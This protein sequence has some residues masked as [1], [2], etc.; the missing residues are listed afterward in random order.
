MN[1]NW[2]LGHFFLQA[3]ERFFLSL[4]WPQC[5][6]FLLDRRSRRGIVFLDR[7]SMNF[8]WW[9]IIPKISKFCN[10]LRSLYLFDSCILVW[11]GAYSFSA[12]AVASERKLF[13][14]KF[15]LVWF[16]VVLTVINLV[17][18]ASRRSSWS[19]F[20]LSMYQDVI[21]DA[22]YLLQTFQLV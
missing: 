18:T 5:H 2:R 6:S 15:A 16:K 7:F 11:I 9:L 4:H 12:K 17:K 3:R 22:Y 21:R 8:C 20:R 19:F 10:I 14:W 13:S 1:G